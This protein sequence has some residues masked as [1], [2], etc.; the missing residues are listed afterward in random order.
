[1]AESN[2][3]VAHILDRGS[4][5]GEVCFFFCSICVQ[6]MIC[7]LQETLDPPFCSHVPIGNDHSLSNNS[8]KTGLDGDWCPEV[9]A[10]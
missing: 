7:F 9:S 1:M 2:I 6:K 8:G 4:R 5:G 10:H 3:G